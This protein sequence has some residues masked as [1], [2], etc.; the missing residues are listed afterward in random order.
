MLWQCRHITFAFPRPS[1]VMGIVNVT[2]DSFSDGGRFLDPAAALAHGRALLAEGADILDVG[3][4]STR[5]GAAPVD[6]AEE[7]RRVLPVIR[8]LAADGAVLSVDTMKPGV[9][10]AALAAGAVIVNDVAAGRPDDAMAR[11]VAAAGAGYVAMHMQGSPATMQREPRYADVVAEVDAFFAAQ[12]ERLARAGVRAEQV[13]LDP[14]FGFGKTAH[15]NL[16]LLA[17]LGAFTRLRRP[18]LV[19]V[20]RKSFLGHVTGAAVEGRLPAALACTALAAEA[21]AAIFRTHDVRATRHALALTEAVVA[22]RKP[23]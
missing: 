6:E 16:G 11:A 10:E 5:P 2:P 7:L 22:Q 19:G 17:G 4:E 1:L 12:L 21:G 8:G 9:A 23:T 15:H 18:V 20:S 13:A 14:G 3:G